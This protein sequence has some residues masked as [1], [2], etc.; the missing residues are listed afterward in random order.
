M[1]RCLTLFGLV[2]MSTVCVAVSEKREGTP[3]PSYSLVVGDGGYAR[4]MNTP[5]SF[6]DLT[7]TAWV[8]I[9]SFPDGVAPILTAVA[10]DANS[11]VSFFLRHDGLGVLW[12]GPPSVPRYQMDQVDRHPRTQ[13]RPIGLD[14]PHRE[15]RDAVDYSA[16]LGDIVDILADS[17]SGRSYDTWTP[18]GFID[19]DQMGVADLEASPSG[20]NDDLHLLPVR[21]GLSRSE[22]YNDWT[23]VPYELT[24]LES[25]PYDLH[26]AE[27]EPRII[28]EPS[29]D[30]D[31]VFFNWNVPAAP[32]QTIPQSPNEWSPIWQSKK[33]TQVKNTQ[34]VKISAE[35]IT[36]K[37]SNSENIN[38]STSGTWSAQVTE[39]K[40]SP[41]SWTPHHILPPASIT[42]TPPPPPPVTPARPRPATRRTTTTK[43]ARPTVPQYNPRRTTTRRTTTTTQRPSSTRRP[44]T[45]EHTTTTTRRPSTTSTTTK[46]TTT[47]LF[48]NK[49]F[50]THR[51]TAPPTTLVPRSRTRV[52][53]FT[54]SSIPSSRQTTRM[55]LW[56][57]IKRPNISQR[58]SSTSSTPKTTSTTTTT[59]TTP[60]PTTTKATTRV[61]TTRTTTSKPTTHQPSPL[62]TVHSTIL[63][64]VTD[65]PHIT[66]QKSKVSIWSS[67]ADNHKLGKGHNYQDKS[68]S[69][70][71]TPLNISKDRSV[72]ITPYH[73]D[74][75]Q[76]A[77]QGVP[78]ISDGNTDVVYSIPIT[79]VEAFNAMYKY[80]QTQEAKAFS[81]SKQAT[82]VHEA[83]LKTIEEE[84]NENY[85]GGSNLPHQEDRFP[86]HYAT[87]L[88]Q[89]NFEETIAPAVFK[90]E[91]AVLVPTED[92]LPPTPSRSDIPIQDDDSDVSYHRDITMTKLEKLQPASTSVKPMLVTQISTQKSQP[93]VSVAI[94]EEPKE[95][96]KTSSQAK[97]DILDFNLPS[98]KDATIGEEVKKVPDQPKSNNKAE[99]PIPLNVKSSFAIT[100]ESTVLPV[101][102][103][104]TNKPL[105]P[106][107]S[108]PSITSSSNLPVIQKPN[109]LL[110]VLIPSNI[111]SVSGSSSFSSLPILGGLSTALKQSGI[112]SEPEPKFKV[113]PTSNFKTEPDVSAQEIPQRH[114]SSFAVF[115]VDE[116]NIPYFPTKG[117]K[118]NAF[119]VEELYQP[120][121]VLVSQEGGGHPV[122]HYQ[123]SS[124][125][126][127]EQLPPQYISPED[128]PRPIAY[129]GPPQQSTNHHQVKD[130][131]EDIIFSANPQE[132]LNQGLLPRPVHYVSTQEEADDW[133]RDQVSEESQIEDRVFTVASPDPYNVV[134]QAPEKS[135]E[136]NN[137]NFNF[138]KLPFDFKTNKWYHIAFTWNSRNH[139]VAVYINGQL[140]GTLTNVLPHQMALAGGGLTLIGQTLLPD[141]T[142]FDPT[143][144]FIGEISDVNMWNKKLSA[145][146]IQNVYKCA[147]TQ[148]SPALNWHQFS[149]RFYSDVLVKQADSVCGA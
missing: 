147:E 33:E 136:E 56:K 91:E 46:A 97:H 54:R 142:D 79:D 44:T 78:P 132:L 98:V 146:S 89:P 102:S 49:H 148:E 131:L 18:Y 36:V 76:R 137:V 88:E 4:L 39:V 68:S 144:Q 29:G 21:D 86:I 17:R 72:N 139:Q 81:N 126:F 113:I 125:L 53:S 143:S 2:V 80:Y 28:T 129:G 67:A 110:S 23:N 130:N 64:E 22:S 128:I 115:H 117:E 104:V 108:N 6:S 105:V 106:E 93:E 92:P 48:N 38:P 19:V 30:D 73:M 31:F 135:T 71:L 25:D 5:S 138:R 37:D 13:W 60:P 63:E 83:V 82:G 122:S 3:S 59:T 85:L 96:Q 87:K 140:A 8:N 123:E 1:T 32:K 120:A 20:L 27:P 15:R 58:P 111:P 57:L 61:R 47:S 51:F 41:N 9:T 95:T 14:S 35:N 145:E 50:T 70:L 121:G 90:E 84:T 141:L 45:T 55:P 11:Q 43:L 101:S 107:P 99:L 114:S 116:D 75:F 26:L 118:E 133:M 24:M 16:G 127:H 42:A 10:P 77:M 52:T 124:H 134:P 69:K 34:T 119:S 12:G 66:G 7:L 103:E 74:E 149:L 65:K 100:Q 94:K 62:P 109:E 112:S 40:L